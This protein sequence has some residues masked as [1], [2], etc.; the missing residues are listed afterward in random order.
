MHQMVRV[1]I[2]DWCDI[3]CVAEGE[4]SLV[5]ASQTRYDAVLLDIDLGRGIGG[6]E[7]LRELKK[8]PKYRYVPVIATTAYA[9]DGDR[10]RFLLG[11]FDAYIS[12]P[13]RKKDLRRVL[14]EALSAACS[15]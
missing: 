13:F 11:G 3:D 4:S 9:L 12:K 2:D 15:Q 6:E 7:V 10:E 8:Q 1:M 5:L 14:E